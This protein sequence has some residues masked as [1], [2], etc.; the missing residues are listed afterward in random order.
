MVEEHCISFPKQYLK[1]K[2]IKKR[3]RK[4]YKLSLWRDLI[5]TILGVI[6]G[7]II[8][9]LY[10]DYQLKK[11]HKKALEQVWNEIRD[12]KDMLIDFNHQM[13]SKFEAYKIFDKYLGKDLQVIVPKDSIEVFKKQAEE[14][15][16]IDSMVSFS[17][18]EVKLTGDFEINV[19]SRL[20]GGK[21]RNSVWTAFS[22]NASLLRLT[23]FETIADL[24]H[25]HTFQL[26]VNEYTMNW[27][28]VLHSDFTK[29]ENDREKFIMDWFHL[30]ANQR[31]L[32]AI[33]EQH[34]FEFTKD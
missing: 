11:E 14:V 25:I 32:I 30:V 34:L 19:G 28:K 24:E 18:A 12:N 13:N 31:I 23:D 16:K 9:N 20:L 6:L 26:E 1:L 8:T 21:L 5:V 7:L 17:D 3:I 29:S 22:R 33:Y 2:K 10:Q 15:F 4:I 27:K